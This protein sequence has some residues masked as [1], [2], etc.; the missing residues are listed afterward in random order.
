MGILAK[1]SRVTSLASAYI[2]AG[3]SRDKSF[4]LGIA[5]L[6]E[7]A[8]ADKDTYIITEKG[9]ED[10]EVSG[11]GALR[12]EVIKQGAAA[13]V[14]LSRLLRVRK[15]APRVWKQYVK[16][17]YP[18]SV[19]LVYR[20]LLDKETPKTVRVPRVLRNRLARIAK[21]AEKQNIRVTFHFSRI[22]K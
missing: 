6:V 1:L 10:R 3:E 18:R 21:L 12:Y 19:Q 22:G 9:K 4:T 17:Q 13:G 14:A 5:P 15:D 16:G 2:R 11:I 7:I 20:E 8:F